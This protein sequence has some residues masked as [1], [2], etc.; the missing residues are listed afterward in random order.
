M[1]LDRGLRQSV[2][3]RVAA[4]G[5]IIVILAGNGW[6]VEGLL[7]RAVPTWLAYV[8]YAGVAVTFCGAI[9]L[10][11]LIVLRFVQGLQTKEPP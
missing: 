6:L 11:A 8:F 10:G 9:G 4:V 1:L 5:F 3:S 7:G 2:P